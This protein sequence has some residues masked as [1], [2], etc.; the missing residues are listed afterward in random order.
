[1]PDSRIHP[2][3]QEKQKP[4]VHVL[5]ELQAYSRSLSQQRAGTTGSQIRNHSVV[6]RIANDTIVKICGPRKNMRLLTAKM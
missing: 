4:A 6:I 5:I 2:S 1:M 3:E